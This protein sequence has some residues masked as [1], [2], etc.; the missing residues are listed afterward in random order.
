[1]DCIRTIGER[2]M[3]GPAAG[4]TNRADRLDRAIDEARVATSEA[5]STSDQRGLEA[6]GM[7]RTAS[8]SPRLVGD[9]RYRLGGDQLLVD[10]NGNSEV[11]AEDYAIAIA[12]LLENG[13]RE[14]ERIT[15]AW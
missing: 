11:S 8:A 2:G 13:G 9:G 5:T 12:D 14:R 4:R 7:S 3:L 10:D 6:A 15:V 1:M